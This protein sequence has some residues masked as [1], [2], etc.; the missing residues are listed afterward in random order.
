MKK[1][2]EHTKELRK[3]TAHEWITKKTKE[4][5]YN[6]NVLITNKEMAEFARKEIPNKAE[7]LKKAIENYMHKKQTA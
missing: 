5:G 2:T 1:I 7:F 4:G 3:K 6:F